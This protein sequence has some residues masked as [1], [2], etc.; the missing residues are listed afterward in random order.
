MF[1]RSKLIQAA[2][3]VLAAFLLIQAS[4]AVSCAIGAPGASQMSHSTAE[5]P[6]DGAAPTHGDAGCATQ[7]FAP[8]ASAQSSVALDM[9]NAAPAAIAPS[10][11]LRIRLLLPRYTAPGPMAGAPPPL[12]P[13]R[14]LLH[15][16]LI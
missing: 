7:C 11:G 9:R 13:H 16:F 12:V 4:F 6:C 3:V 15:S 10:A 1:L 14:V 8:T 2:R 5:S